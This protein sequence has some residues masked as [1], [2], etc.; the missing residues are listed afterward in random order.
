MGASVRRVFYWKWGRMT[1]L[2]S[3]NGFYAVY[4]IKSSQKGVRI[5]HAV[6][7][8]SRYEV[9]QQVHLL[10]AHRLYHEAFI[11][12]NKEYAARLARRGQLPQRAASS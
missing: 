1:H 10:L 4:T 9:H 11:I 2:R 8:V 6:L 3:A 5:V 7:V 12:R